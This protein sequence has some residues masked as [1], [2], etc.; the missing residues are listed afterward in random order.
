VSTGRFL[1]LAFRG[2][3]GAP[4]DVTGNVTGSRISVNHAQTSCPTTQVSNRTT[5]RHKLFA[6]MLTSRFAPTG[7]ALGHCDL[8]H[9]RFACPGAVSENYGLSLSPNLGSVRLHGYHGGDG[10]CSRGQRD[11]PADRAGRSRG[12]ASSWRVVRSTS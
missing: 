7:A 1:C 12:S 6:A 2:N 5:E 11:N 4:V 9:G 3:F 10:K 8:E